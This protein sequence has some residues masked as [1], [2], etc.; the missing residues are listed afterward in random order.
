LFDHEGKYKSYYDFYKKFISKE[1]KTFIQYA[2]ETST[3]S[4]FGERFPID[5]KVEAKINPINDKDVDCQFI[6]G[7]FKYNIE[8]KCSDFVSKE[9]IDNQD[10]FKYGT[11]GRLPDRGKEAIETISSALD[12]GLTKKGEQTKPHLESKNMDNNLKDFLEL[13][14]EKF[15]PTPKENEINVL[16]IGCDDERDMQNW[17]NYLWAEQGLFTEQSFANKDNY[18][19]VDLVVFTNLYF[20]HNKYFNKELQNFWSLEK[21]FNLIFGNPYR[22]SQKEAGIKHFMGIL[23]NFT[24]ELGQYKVSGDAPDYVK[25]SVKIPW[26]V[27]DN[28]EKKQEVFFFGERKSN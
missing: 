26:F 10:A 9:T 15:D 6:D 25:G 2:V 27:R 28:L 24:T 20:K 4:Y 17:F 22:H 11:I 16:L 13:A 12:E 23:P 19:N 3:V 21:S 18:K 7:K 5:F 14:H 8:V 1:E